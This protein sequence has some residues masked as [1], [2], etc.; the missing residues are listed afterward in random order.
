MRSSATG[1]T[2]RS[3][4]FTS[5]T[6][7]CTQFCSI[8]T[9][10]SRTLPAGPI[11]LPLECHQPCIVAC[12][13]NERILNTVAIKPGG[14]FIFEADNKATFRDFNRAS[15]DNHAL[16]V[17]GGESGAHKLNY[18][19]DSEAMGEQDRLGAAVHIS[20]EQLDRAAAVG[21]GAASDAG[22]CP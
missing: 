11:A 14:T 12:E 1:V 15:A 10:A 19:F 4:R 5:R 17:C 2:S 6:A 13:D 8:R 20:R 16:A 7:T 18:L 21:L 9:R 3:L 22:H